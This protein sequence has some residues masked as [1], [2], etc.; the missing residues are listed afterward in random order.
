MNSSS[1]R[2]SATTRCSS[3]ERQREIRA[4]PGRQMQVG[5][6]GGPGAARIDDDQLAAVLPQFGEIAQRGRHRLGEVRADE[7]HAP[8]PRD[9]LQRERQPPV[10]TERPLMRGRR[11]RHAEAPVVV[12]LRGAEHDPRELPERVRLLVGQ[13][14]AAEDAARRP[15]RAPSACARSPSAI[16]SR[17]SSQVAGSSPPVAWRGPGA[18]SGAPGRRAPRAR[19]GPCR[20]AR[21]GSPGS[22]R[23]PRPRPPRRRRRR[24]F[25]PHCRAQYGQW[26]GVAVGAAGVAGARSG[27]Q[28]G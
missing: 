1:V 21:P 4:G 2:P 5:L 27:I 13:P 22:P 9:V 11:R 26:V 12:D 16:R 25:M 10:E 28:P 17:A 14:A 24:R 15:G 23:A 19:Y 7:D 20:T 6:L 18:R 3:P 8:G